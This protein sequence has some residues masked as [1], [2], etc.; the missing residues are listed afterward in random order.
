MRS[1]RAID[2]AIDASGRVAGCYVHGL[3][4]GGAQRAAWLAR[5]GAGSDGI[6]QGRR[7]DAALDELAGELER[8]VD[9]ERLLGIARAQ[10]QV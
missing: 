8:V 2:G 4:D 5:L 10:R 7:T 9:V 6:D 3:L 1:S